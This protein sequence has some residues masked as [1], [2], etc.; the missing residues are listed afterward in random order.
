MSLL[1][2]QHAW[3]QFLDLAFYL[4]TVWGDYLGATVS[5]PQF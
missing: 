3:L 2:L 5:I 4:G 1:F